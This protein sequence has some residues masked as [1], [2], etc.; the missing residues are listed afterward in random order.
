MVYSGEEDRKTRSLE[1]VNKELR[2]RLDALEKKEGVQ[3][4]PSIPSE[5]GGDS[6]DVWGDFMEVE[7]ETDW[8]NRR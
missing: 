7:D 5:E 8:M 6:E 3:G 1:A 2:A 4:G